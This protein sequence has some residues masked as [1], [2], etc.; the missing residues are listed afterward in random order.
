MIN[1]FKKDGK[2][3]F[4]LSD[5]LPVSSGYFCFFLQKNSKYSAEISKR[6]LTNCTIA[7]ISW[8]QQKYFVIFE[9]VFSLVQLWETGL[10]RRWVE[11]AISYRKADKCFV[12][13]EKA[14]TSALQVAI[15]L[16]DLSSAFFILGIG[17]ALAILTLLAEMSIGSWQRGTKRN[18]A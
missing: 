1:Q 5:P 11:Q 7:C 12:R 14:Q 4:Q 13:K 17:V 8:K 9:I 15:K 2:C 3:R 16:E 6:Y 18:Q 10:T